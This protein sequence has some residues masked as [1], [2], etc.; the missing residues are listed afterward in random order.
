MQYRCFYLSLCLLALGF[1]L[2]GNNAVAQSQ[3]SK[4][5]AQAEP[6]GRIIVRYR[7]EDPGAGLAALQ[8]NEKRTDSLE[9]KSFRSRK[10]MTL[11][12]RTSSN[13]E[14]VSVNTTRSGNQQIEL[15][16]QAAILAASPDIESASV[17]YRRH[18]LAEPNDPLFRQSSIPGKQTYLYEGTYSV[19]APGAWDITTGSQNSV[20]AIIDTGV[21]G[22]HPDLA[23]RAIAGMGYDFVSADS[24][25]NFTS[26]ND[27]DGRD[28]DPTDPGDHCGFNSSSWHGSGVASVAAGNSNNAEGIAGIDWNSRLLH[29]RA[30]GRCGGTDADIIDAIRWSAG[31]PVAGLP[32]NPTPATVVNLSIGGPTECTPAWQQVIDE[33]NALNI[34]FVIAAGNEANN[35][36]RSSPANC[37]DVI[38]VG[39]STPD[40][41]IDRNFSNYGLKVTVTAPGRDIVMATNSGSTTAKEN[42]SS[43][44]LET[45]SSFSAAIVSGAISLMQSLNDQLSPAQVRTLL[46]NSA[47]PFA[48]DG[49][50]ATYYCG[51]GTL[52]LSRIVSMVRDGNISGTDTEQQV[53]ENLAMPL[54]V[55]QAVSGSVFGYRDIRY[56]SITTQQAGVLTVTSDSDADLYGYLLNDKLSVLAL[57]DDSSNSFNFKVASNVAAGN[58]Y[59]AV[60]RARHFINDGEAAFEITAE[61]NTDSPETFSFTPVVDASINTAVRSES[62]IISGL[63]DAA[64]ISVS[65]GFY[66]LNDSPPTDVQGTVVNGDTVF[67]TLQSA[68]SAQSET[69]LQLSVGAYATGFSVTTRETSTDSKTTGGGSGCTMLDNKT[70]IIPD[71]TLPALLL[72]A[73]VHLFR[74]RKIRVHSM[75]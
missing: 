30:L 36:L 55:S 35:A 8:G 56:Y 22:G 16:R 64:V 69:S 5:A 17:E 20:I 50:C 54:P 28:A 6:T 71:P 13:G 51:T 27:G 41:N 43:Y 34:P 49:E 33:L 3:G 38:T 57:D 23:D 32:L 45:G 66:S 63:Q 21:L 52:N 58:Y 7:R 59:L 10:G 46:Q 60:E 19:R 75:R 61:V 74:T 62:I 40:G 14:L 24:A 47:S 18:L 25:D 65:G 42:G 11:I 44:K 2:A 15:K 1:N 4:N 48:T 67:V 70:P 73:C 68:G 26:A 53:I 72:L 29:A 12:R 9:R 31:L 39:S 37:A